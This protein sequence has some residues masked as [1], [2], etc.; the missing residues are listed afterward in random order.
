[1]TTG[2]DLTAS[3][4]KHKVPAPSGAGSMAAREAGALI[5]RFSHSGTAPATVIE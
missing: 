4:T 3:M 1:M 2:H 5:E